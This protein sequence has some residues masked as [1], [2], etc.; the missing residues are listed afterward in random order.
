MI[1]L[2]NLVLSLILILCAFT[3]IL[4]LCRIIKLLHKI[5]RLLKPKKATRIEIYA[6]INGKLTKVDNMEL[7]VTEQLPLALV[8]KD[9][10]GNVVALPAG[11]PVWSQTPE[12]LTVLEVAVDGLTAVLKPNGPVGM[13]TLGATLDLLVAPAVQVELVPGP[14]ATIE[15]VPGTPVVM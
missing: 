12:D 13:V 1:I 3:I 11:M 4:C 9:A 8:A 5:I 7:K 6:I 15:I 10:K 14:V 2:T